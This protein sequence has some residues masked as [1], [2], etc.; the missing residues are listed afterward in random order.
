MTRILEAEEDGTL[1]LPPDVLGNVQPHTRYVLETSG[2]ELTLRPEPIE[3]TKQKQSSKKTKASIEAWE[4][5]R[6]KLA[7]DLSKV[8][9]DGLSSVDAVSEIRR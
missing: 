8:W 3:A 1:T 2:T 6:K 7:D 4:Q 9:P 5:K